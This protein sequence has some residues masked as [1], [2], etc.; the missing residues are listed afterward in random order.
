M[1]PTLELQARRLSLAAT[2]TGQTRR[3]L[4]GRIPPDSNTA[5]LLA[6]AR[7]LREQARPI[8]RAHSFHFEPVYPGAT[9]GPEV[10]EGGLRLVLA[11]TAFNHDGAP[12]GVV[13]T[14]LIPGRF[15]QVSVAPVGARIPEGWQPLSEPL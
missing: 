4:G 2:L 13:F 7:S 1:D 14:T 12:L 9:A 10:V 11:C 5:D 8:E 3:R 15:P 6:L